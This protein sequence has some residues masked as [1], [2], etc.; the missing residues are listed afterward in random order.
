[1]SFGRASDVPELPRKRH[2]MAALRQDLAYAFRSLR[3]Q[4]GFTATAILMLALGTGANIAIFALVNA[5]LMRPLPFA[6]PDRL[7]LVHMLAPDRESPGT[8]RHMIWS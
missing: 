8:Y 1:R 4:P 3:K 2:A 5:V 6:E 7:M